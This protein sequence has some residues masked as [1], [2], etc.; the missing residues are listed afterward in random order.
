MRRPALV[1]AMVTS[2]TVLAQT[3]LPSFDDRHLYVDAR[4]GAR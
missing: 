2:G 4:V 1:V 3:D